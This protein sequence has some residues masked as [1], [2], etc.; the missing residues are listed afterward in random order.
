MIEN[1]LIEISSLDPILILGILFFFSYIENIFPPSPSDVVVFFGAV[2]ITGGKGNINFIPVLLI[3]SLGSALGF[4]TMYFIGKYF[5]DKII[6]TGKIKFITKDAI[7]KTDEWFA[8]FGYA[9]VVINRFLPGLRAVISFF[10]G[11]SNMEFF[12]TFLFA[13]IS[14]AIWNLCLILAGMFIGR[15]VKLFEYYFET[16]STVVTII[17]VLIIVFFVARNIYIKY[18]T[19]S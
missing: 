10:C 11:L 15:N 17:I 8:R 9:L 3:T 12:K 14:S 2:L 19:K 5:G 18:R 7:K 6:R 13:A 16:Y 4:I 1:I